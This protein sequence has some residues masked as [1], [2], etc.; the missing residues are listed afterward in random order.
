MST[1]LA[2]GFS[3]STLGSTDVAAITTYLEE[4][5]LRGDGLVG[6]GKLSISFPRSETIS[7]K[8]SSLYKNLDC[9]RALEARMVPLLDSMVISSPL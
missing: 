2:N 5:L 3:S 1:L 8:F 7:P 4:Q 9:V 6:F